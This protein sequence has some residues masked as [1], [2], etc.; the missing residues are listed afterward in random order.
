L[1]ICYMPEKDSKGVFRSIIDTIDADTIMENKAFKVQSNEGERHLI[2]IC[3]AE[4]D[5]PDQELSNFDTESY[6]VYCLIQE[7]IKTPKYRTWFRYVFPFRRFLSTLTIY[8]VVNF[9]DSIGNTDW[10]EHGGDMWE[11]KGGNWSRSFRKW[12][13]KTF[14][15]ARKQGRKAFMS[16]YDTTQND[17]ESTDD[18]PDPSSP[19]TFL[20]LLKP[21]LNFEDG[22]RWWQRGRQVKN[23]PYDADGKICD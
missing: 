2:P 3:S 23:K 10:P 19:S 9:L 17:Y 18:E 15:K 16:L 4:L 11:T 12:N 20:E 14:K 1:R 13:K 8:S 7:M 5:I 22:L 21:K 6:D